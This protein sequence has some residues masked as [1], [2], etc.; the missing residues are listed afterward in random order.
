[1][2]DNNH[3]S[4][5]TPENRS[6]ARAYVYQWLAE[7]YT[8]PIDNKYADFDTTALRDALAY[9]ELE[10]QLQPEIRTLEKGLQERADSLETIVEFCRLFYG[11]HKVPAPPFGSYWLEEGTLLGETTIAVKNTYNK[12]GLT[13]SPNAKTHP[14]HLSIE[15]EF[16]Y[17]LA[18]KEEEAREAKD[19]SQAC[20]FLIAQQEFLQNYLLL[21][22][23]PFT[24]KVTYS[25]E[26]ELFVGLSKL[27][28]AFLKADYYL[29]NDLKISYQRH[30]HLRYQ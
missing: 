19:Y 5:H 26:M 3:I 27:T 16:M 20:Q 8:N 23:Y 7:K 9:L 17:Y 18:V 2:K 28:A 30:R 29:I 11:P 13:L 25:T 4:N 12:W 15:L 22:V 21:W 10:E 14:D 24:E 6:E 1:M